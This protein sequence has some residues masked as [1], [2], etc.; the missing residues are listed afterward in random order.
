M[1]FESFASNPVIGDTNGT[2]EAFVRDRHT[3]TTSRVSVASDGSEGIGLGYWAWLDHSPVVAVSADGRIVA[4]VSHVT[5]PV[6]GDT[7]GQGDIFVHGRATGQTSRVSV[8]SDGTEAN[9]ESWGPALSADGR[10]VAHHSGVSNWPESSPAAGIDPAV[11]NEV[12][13]HNASDIFLHDRGTAQT[14]RVSVAS[15]GTPGNADSVGAALTPDTRYVAF[16]SMA[17]NLVASD[18]N[19]YMWD[20]F[21]RDRLTGQTALVSLTASGATAN[22]GSYQAAISA[23][24]RFVAFV[25][26]ATNLVAGDTNLMLDVLCVT[27]TRDRPP[28]SPLPRMGV[29]ATT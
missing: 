9:W 28:A 29:R 19:G 2:Y 22:A 25:S 3:Q 27:S 10:Y 1:A 26:E 6:P 23:N 21:V 5:G 13:I 4:F 12:G 14:T 11:G 18:A 16:A 17:N 24:G 7:N 8:A 20:V 15:D